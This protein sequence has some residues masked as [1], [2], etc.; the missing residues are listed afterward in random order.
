MWQEK[1]Y[2]TPQ[3]AT[4]FLG[5]Y[6]CVVTLTRRLSDIKELGIHTVS[7]STPKPVLCYAAHTALPSCLYCAAHVLGLQDKLSQLTVAFSQFPLGTGDYTTCMSL[8]LRA[9][10]EVLM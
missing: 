2:P 10:Q 8:C 4:A 1:H 6:P 9:Q 5:Y 3:P 7:L